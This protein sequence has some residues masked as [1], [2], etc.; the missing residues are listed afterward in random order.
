MKFKNK[1]EILKDWISKSNRI[2]IFTGAGI[3][4]ASGIP[5]FRSP[6][7]IYKKKY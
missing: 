1:I 3:S 7:G 6:N 5:D 2:V 4:V